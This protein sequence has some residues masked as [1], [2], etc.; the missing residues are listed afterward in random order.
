MALVDAQ[1]IIATNQ[2]K[3]ASP[4]VSNPPVADTTVK[5]KS[6]STK[7]VLTTTQWL[8]VMSILVSLAGIYYRENIKSLLTPKQP[9]ANTTPPAPPNSPVDC[10]PKTKGGICKMD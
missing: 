5:S 9:Q 8:S 4:P 7:D 6:E 1:A 2:L 3:Q 10:A